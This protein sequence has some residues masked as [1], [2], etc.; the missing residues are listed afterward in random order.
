MVTDSLELV[1]FTLDLVKPKVGKYQ[2]LGYMQGGN[3][4]VTNKPL[5]IFA[6]FSGFARLRMGQH[7]IK[8]GQNLELGY[9]VTGILEEGLGNP[10]CKLCHSQHFLLLNSACW[11]LARSEYLIQ[12]SQIHFCHGIGLAWVESYLLLET[13]VSLLARL[14]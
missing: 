13:F 7:A 3:A 6:R 4:L 8:D 12:L 14:H 1:D 5:I 2:D 10:F 11:I 9:D